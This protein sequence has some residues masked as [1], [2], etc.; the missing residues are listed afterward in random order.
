MLNNELIYKDTVLEK[1]V[2]RRALE[3]EHSQEGYKKHYEEFFGKI[4]DAILNCLDVLRIF[5]TTTFANAE[6]IW[7]A[8]WS[9]SFHGIKELRAWG[10]EDFA[11]LATY[12]GENQCITNEE[13][14]LVIQQCPRHYFDE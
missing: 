3:I 11:T 12:Y 9:S 4:I 7:S 8:S 13:K 2:G 10:N 1:Q 6:K 5:Q 14:Q